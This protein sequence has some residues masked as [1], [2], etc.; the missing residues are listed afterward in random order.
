MAV[1]VHAR[2]SADARRGR[3]LP[4]CVG[5]AVALAGVFPLTL[6][7]LVDCRSPSQ[8]SSASRQVSFRPG[9]PV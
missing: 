5:R 9:Q 6:L 8:R 4:A 2:P 7:R 1:H 3:Q